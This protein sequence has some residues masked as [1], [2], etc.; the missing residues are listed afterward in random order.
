MTSSPRVVVIGAGIVGANLAD[1]LTARGWDRVT[2]LDQGPLPL[3]GG[4]SSHAPGLM[5]QTNASKTMTEFARYTVEKFAGLHVDGAWC[6]NQVGGLEVATTPARLADLHRRLGWATS[7]GVEGRVVDAPEC[8]RLHP[9][10]DRD[11]VRGGLHVPTDG[12]A[13]ASRAVVALARRAEARG[14]RFQGSTRVVGIEQSGGRVTG[15]RTTGGVLPADVVVSCAG[16]WG[17]AV[18]AMVGMEVPL[19]PLAHQYART[20]QIAELV[21][22]NDDLAEAGLPVLRHQDEDLYFREH[23]DRLGIGTYAHRPM[24]VRLSDLAV[25]GEIDAASMPS[26]LPFTE[27]DFAP[28]WEN[29]RRLLPALGSAKVEEAFNGVFSFTPDGGPLIGE[30]ADVAGFW[31]AEAVWVTHSA[32]VGRAVAQLLVDGRSEID[33]HG[34]DV[35]RFE[36]VA[37]GEDYVGETAQQNF[38]E[39]YDVLHPLEPRESPRGLRVSPFH[40]RQQELGAVFLEAGG[41]ERPHWYEANA[42]LVADLPP[43]WVPP[44]RDDWSARFHSPIAAAEAW[45]TREAVALYDMTP[46]K[47][48]EVSGPGA[49]ALLDRLTTNTMDKPVGAVTYTLALDAAGGIRSDLTVARLGPELF[50]VGANGN[51]DRDHLRREARADTH[52]RDITGGTCCVGVWGPAA[53]DLVQPLSHDDFSHEGLPYFRAIRA[54]V[55][56]VPVTAMRLSYVGELGWEIYMSAEYGQ[57]LW[58]VLWAAGRDLGVIAAGRAA[59]NSLRLEKGYRAWGHDM[60]TEH[61]PYEAGLGFAVRPRKGDFV[62]RDAIAGLSAETV[63]RR[64]S[65]LTVDDGVGMVLGHEPVYLD[66]RP[67]GYVTSAAFGHTVGRPVAYAWLPASATPGTAVEIGY[68]DRRIAATVTPE[69]LVDPQMTRIRR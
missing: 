44:E 33:L 2:V 29:A 14:A 11:R 64:L 7:W 40:A 19:L 15:V 50:Q 12:L 56:G 13:K 18:G 26:M 54:H 5:F 49:L 59:F 3:T 17:R 36:D 6:L 65:C 43:G 46:L 22:R 52:V 31:I 21:G 25:D 45:R 9:L 39:V 57:R 68:F 8:V 16:F 60:T 32:G 38:V 66:G 51:L 67:A 48:L 23:G 24:P 35:H 28:S 30:S 61:N 34:C 27:D 37:L 42:G 63:T 41:W 55:G 69:P 20:G 10:L 1:E 47:R 58:D 62:G 4:S 53:R